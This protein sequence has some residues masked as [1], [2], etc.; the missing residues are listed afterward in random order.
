M[1][2]YIVNKTKNITPVGPRDTLNSHFTATRT[3]TDESSVCSDLTSTTDRKKSSTTKDN[4][5]E[6]RG[7]LLVPIMTKMKNGLKR[8]VSK[9]KDITGM[10]IKIPM[11]NSR[12]GQGVRIGKIKR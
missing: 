10:V 12:D 6:L 4:T 2:T 11:L 5:I 3:V 1:I 8:T 7:E 9:D